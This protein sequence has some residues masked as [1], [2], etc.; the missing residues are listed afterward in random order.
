[1]YKKILSTNTKCHG[2]LN[3]GSKTLTWVKQLQVEF[4]TETWVN[5]S[6]CQYKAAGKVS[7]DSSLAPLCCSHFK[8]VLHF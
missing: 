7:L 1:M 4:V 2:C 3:L 6:V 8:K 5:L